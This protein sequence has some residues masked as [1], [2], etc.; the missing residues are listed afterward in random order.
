MF[1]CSS[2]KQPEEKARKLI[3]DHLYETLHDYKSYEPIKFGK[4]DSTFTSFK[5]DA[6]YAAARKTFDSLLDASEEHLDQAKRYSSVYLY[7]NTGRK[8]LTEAEQCNDMAG[9]IA[10][11]LDSFKANFKGKFNGWSMTHSYRAKS[12]GG[13]LGIS[14]DRYYFNIAI[15]SLLESRDNSRDDDHSID[16]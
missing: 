5:D 14:H 9:P 1:S 6:A 2:K 13:N 10:I 7:G 8:F 12:L 15:D 4:L 16:K 3:K 11:W